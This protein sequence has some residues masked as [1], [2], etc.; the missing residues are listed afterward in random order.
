MKSSFECG[1]I[2]NNLTMVLAKP[3]LRVLFK[4]HTFIEIIPAYPIKQSNLLNFREGR[5]KVRG[6]QQGGG[7]EGGFFQWGWGGNMQ[8]YATAV[9]V[10]YSTEK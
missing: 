5:Q 1:T 9:K 4:K 8:R 6:R 10:G 3:K 7:G 2:S